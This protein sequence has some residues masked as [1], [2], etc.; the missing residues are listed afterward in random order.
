MVMSMFR[1]APDDDEFEDPTDEDEQEPKDEAADEDS[2]EASDTEDSAADD[3]SDDDAPISRKEFAALEKTAQELRTS[4]G[5]A[6][7]VLDRLDNRGAQEEMVAEMRQQNAATAE[8]F[9]VVVNGLAPNAIDPNLRAQINAAADEIAAA[10][11]KASMLDELKRELGIDPNKP[12]DEDYDELQEA[13]NDLAADLE[14]EIRAEGMDPDDNT[15]FNWT[16]WAETIKT[17]GIR[18][19][20]VQARREIKEAAKEEQSGARRESRR[21]A[22]GASPRGKAPV[23]KGDPLTSGSLADRIKAL[24]AITR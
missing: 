24:N 1:G 21:A 20:R 15:R 5:R 8:L 9:R 19:A 14:D 16:K 12:S 3:D 23:V 6:R 10:E 7:S 13:A 4:L 11:Q 18:A 2:D 22:S 17:Q